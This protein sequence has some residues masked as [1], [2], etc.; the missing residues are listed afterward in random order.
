MA[1]GRNYKK[2]TAWEDSP[3]QVKRR[4]ARNRARIAAMRKGKVHK[5]DGKEVDH[6]GY[7]P[8]GSLRNVP[9]RVV[10]RRANRKRQPPHKGY[11]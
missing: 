2:E 3:A 4:E 9:T 1:K 7:H 6:T 11:K 8:T 10:S 5:G